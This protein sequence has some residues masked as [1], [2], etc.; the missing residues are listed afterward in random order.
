M[1]NLKN[2]LL[3]ILVFTLSCDSEDIT[4]EQPDITIENIVPSNDPH[5]MNLLGTVTRFIPKNGRT[6]NTDIGE[7]DLTRGIKVTDVKDTITRY[8]LILVNQESLT[9]E[10]IV[11]K[12]NNEGITSYILKYDANPEWL[13]INSGNFKMANFTG[14][15]SLLSI[16]RELIAKADVKNGVGITIERGKTIK[17]GRVNCDGGGGSGGSGGGGG[18][19]GDGS[20]DGGTSG[21]GS[22]SSGG[23]SGGSGGSSGSGSGGSSGGGGGQIGEPCTW[24]FDGTTLDIDC[25]DWGGDG[26]TVPPEVIARV[27]CD[28]PGPAPVYTYDGNGDPI[29]IVNPT[30]TD[31]NAIRLTL[32]RDSVYNHIEN[33]C[34]REMVIKA[35]YEN[36][37][38]QISHIIN[39]VFENSELFDLSFHEVSDLPDTTLGQAMVTHLDNGRVLADVFLNVNVLPNASQEIIV[40]TIIHEVLHA[41]LG[42][43][44]NSQLFNDHEE[45]ANEYIGLM[46]GALQN[47]FPNLSNKDAEALSWGGLHETTAWQR[48]I[49]TNPA[50][51]NKITQ[52]NKDHVKGNKGTDC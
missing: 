44:R 8:S 33:P 22:G 45:M 51:A 7:I 27:K 21:G 13:I 52:I 25:G 18:G 23:S 41:Y 26:G 46:K 50:K 42:Y 11:I 37:D 14:F 12:E 20:G 1:R 2:F 49:N 4:I 3:T 19:S 43:S 40:S 15:V 6:L 17:N 34:L 48:L 30:P 5:L 31:P 38:N 9:F 29:G 39:Q 28:E 16:E 32:V 36:L 24:T 35:V 47:L 10:N